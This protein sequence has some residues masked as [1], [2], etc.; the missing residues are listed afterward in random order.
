MLRHTWN[1]MD[2]SSAAHLWHSESPQCPRPQARSPPAP[3]TCVFPLPGAPAS[4]VTSPVY[5]PASSSWSKLWG[6]HKAGCLM[7]IHKM[8]TVLPRTR[9]YQLPKGRSPGL[10]SHSPALNPYTVGCSSFAVQEDHAEMGKSLGARLEHLQFLCIPTVTSQQRDWK[11]RNKPRQQRASHLLA[12]PWE[13][14]TPN[15]PRSITLFSRGRLRAAHSL[16]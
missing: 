5:S 2:Q 12:Q 8:G 9:T 3:L 4:S 6:E 7:C 14:I 16:V 13:I 10:C 15:P 11:K 1:S